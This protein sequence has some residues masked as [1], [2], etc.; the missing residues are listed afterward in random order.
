MR[1]RIGWSLGSHPLR[2]KFQK[3]TGNHSHTAP[4][5][6]QQFLEVRPLCHIAQPNLIL[7]NKDGFP[8][9]WN[10]KENRN[11]CAYKTKFKTTKREKEGH[12][13]IIIVSIRYE[14]TILNMY[15]SNVGLF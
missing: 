9:Y 1:D 6:S 4:H 13:I 10:P 8:H 12:D 2:G 15:A 3:E 7:L 14:E 5:T 11:S